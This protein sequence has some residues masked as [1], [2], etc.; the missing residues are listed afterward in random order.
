MHKRPSAIGLDRTLR[1]GGA[2]RT[3]FPTD[4]TVV[5]PGA[6]A[7]GSALIAPHTPRQRAHSSLLAF[8]TDPVG[9]HSPLPPLHTEGLARHI[10][11]LARNMPRVARNKRLIPRSQEGCCAR[12]A[13]TCAQQGFDPFARRPCC[14][15]H[16][17]VARNMLRN[18]TPQIRCRLQLDPSCAQQGTCS[19][20]HRATRLA[21]RAAERL[22]LA[23]RFSSPPL[24]VPPL[25]CPLPP[26]FPPL[27][28][29]G[30][31]LQL[32]SNPRNSNH[33]SPSRPA[34]LREFSRDSPRAGQRDAG[35]P[36]GS[37][38]PARSDVSRDRFSSF[39]EVQAVH[40]R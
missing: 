22:P 39:L 32:S 30:R 19:A 15:Q 26:L 1:F 24:P 10:P 14:A 3:P 8:R 27:F 29:A 28:S 37:E 6:R 2:G 35:W 23:S 21:D 11:P 16:L 18:A 5:Q 33:F 12:Q 13:P 25:F 20:Q 7:T 40:D 9:H 38:P 36:G 4:R 31:F 34:G 17:P